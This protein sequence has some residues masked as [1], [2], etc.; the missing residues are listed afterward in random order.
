MAA[1]RTPEALDGGLKGGRLLPRQARPGGIMPPG[2]AAK[3]A[4]MT[5]RLPGKLSKYYDGKSASCYFFGD[6]RKKIDF[7]QRIWY[8]DFAR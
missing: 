1:G 6:D 3:Y 4:G 8:A 7:P 2:R 5:R